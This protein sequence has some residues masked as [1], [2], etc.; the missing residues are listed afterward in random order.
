MKIKKPPMATR[1][2]RP[3]KF[4]Q[5]WLRNH[6]TVGSQYEAVFIGV[7][8]TIMWVIIPTVLWLMRS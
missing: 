3:T 8:I 5:W 4:E 2:R 7:G 6:L 1:L